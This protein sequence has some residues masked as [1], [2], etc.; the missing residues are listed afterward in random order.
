MDS[1]LLIRNFACACGGGMNGWHTVR[2]SVGRHGARGDPATASVSAH[3]T[4]V[5]RGPRIQCTAVRSYRNSPELL[6]LYLDE[7]FQGA[8]GFG[9]ASNVVVAMV[10]GVTW[11]T[12]AAAV[13]L[14]GGAALCAL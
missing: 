11:I 6:L 9:L 13:V 8:I 1:R 14:C 3:E 5:G 12:V 7:W 2:A 10:F 4:P